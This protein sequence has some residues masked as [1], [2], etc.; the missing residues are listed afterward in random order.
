[1]GLYSES[2]DFT[3]DITYEG[4]HEQMDKL[5]EWCN[6]NL[7][8]DITLMPCASNTLPSYMIIRGLFEKEHDATLFALRW[9]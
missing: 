3:V 9:K 1:M 8:G 7:K 5:L 6:A 2:Q 4:N